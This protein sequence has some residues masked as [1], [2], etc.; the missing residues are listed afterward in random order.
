MVR[1]EY[2]VAGEIRPEVRR[3]LEA[4]RPLCPDAPGDSLISEIES[5]I[6]AENSTRMMT[7][8]KGRH[9]TG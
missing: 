6:V 5:V 7:S 8:E 9:T 4:I 2:A 1:L 3:Y